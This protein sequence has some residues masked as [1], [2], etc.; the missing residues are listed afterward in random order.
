VS[1][2]SKI[3]LES[4]DSSSNYN[5]FHGVGAAK[6]TQTFTTFSQFDQSQIEYKGGILNCPIAASM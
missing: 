1:S 4:I 5:G 2:D 3:V 6:N